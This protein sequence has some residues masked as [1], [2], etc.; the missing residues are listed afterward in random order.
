MRIRTKNRILFICSLL[1]DLLSSA[2]VFLL[3]WA[4]DQ[5]QKLTTLGYLAGI[6]FWCGIAAGIGFWTLTFIRCRRQEDYLTVQRAQKAGMISFFKGKGAAAADLLFLLSFI[7]TAVD[8]FAVKLPY[9][10]SLI[11]L[12]VF[13]FSFHLHYLLN[14]KL[15]RYLFGK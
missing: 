12:F 2:S 8:T 13:L 7:I 9:I 4:V 10:L 3:P 5:E 15:Y 1:C 6:V 14:G 11:S